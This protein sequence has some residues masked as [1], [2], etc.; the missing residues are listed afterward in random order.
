MCQTAFFLFFIKPPITA[1]NYADASTNK[2]IKNRLNPFLP[3]SD[4]PNVYV[5]ASTPHGVSIVLIQKP[6]QIILL[7][8]MLTAC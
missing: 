6:S 7:R 4:P 2:K 1:H 8:K 5:R 3:E